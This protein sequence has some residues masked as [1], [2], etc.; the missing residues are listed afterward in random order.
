MAG[1]KQQV[2]EVLDNLLS[3]A[4][5]HMGERP[6]AS[7]LIRVVQN[8]QW[9]TTDVVD[10]GCGIPQEY[11]EKIFDRFF[12]VPGTKEKNG[13]GLGLSI[14]KQIVES[15]HG[16]VWVESVPGKGASFSFTLP[17]FAATAGT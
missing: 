17:K 2:R 12:R 10:N 5:Q 15:H 9:V 16:K 11:H 7:I 1:N 13:S 3:N 6:D 8:G 4:V 14:V